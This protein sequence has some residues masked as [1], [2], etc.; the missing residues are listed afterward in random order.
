MG[1]GAFP[2]STMIHDTPGT[3]VTLAASNVGPS[4][5]EAGSGSGEF[6]VSAAIGAS[7]PHHEVDQFATARRNVGRI[8][9]TLE[10]LARQ[11]DFVANL[12][13]LTHSSIYPVR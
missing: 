5:S 2:A 9:H 4:S 13:H 12:H 7:T 1:F 6:E 8:V 10:H 11:L 3:F